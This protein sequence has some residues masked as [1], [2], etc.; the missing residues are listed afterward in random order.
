MIEK[1]AQI[2]M[3]IVDIAMRDLHLAKSAGATL[4]QRLRGSD[5]YMAWGWDCRLTGRFAGAR[6]SANLLGK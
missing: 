2:N 6:I 1:S 3:R 4:H 5:G